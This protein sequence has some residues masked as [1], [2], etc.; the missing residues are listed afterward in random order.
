[1]P[2]PL[3]EPHHTMYQAFKYLLR[4]HLV[5][6]LSIGFALLSFCIVPTTTSPQGLQWWQSI[7]IKTINLLFCLMFIIEGFRECNLFQALATTLLKG[8][9]TLRTLAFLLTFLTFGLAMFITND[10]ALIA[11][12]PFTLYLL[13]HLHQ[14]ASALS[15]TVTLAIAANLGSMATPIGNPQNLFL[16]TAYTISP[17][18][19]LSL[20]LP[21]TLVGALV[22]LGLCSFIPKTP[23]NSALPHSSLPRLTSPK[24]LTLLTLL[25]FLALATVLRCFPHAW[26]FG[27]ILT[28]GLAFY[29]TTLRH[30]DYGLLFTFIA[31]FIFSHNIQCFEGLQQLLQCALAHAPKTTTILLS[32][33]LSN[34]PAAILLRPFTDNWQALLLGVNIGGFGTLIASLA[35]LI[36]FNFYIKTPQAQPERFLLHFT[37][38]NLL[39]LSVLCI[40]SYVLPLF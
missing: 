28:L 22:L 4:A 29:R 8:I 39:V 37:L 7:D 19:F 33:G 17:S 35:S 32:Q 38:I 2:H 21:L 6:S 5:P 20:M 27:L 23:L 26:L 24:R 25:F 30:L 16:Y 3:A 14:D 1:M 18:A 9:Q 34:V 12:V 40:A 36:A 31:F 11:M 15:L 13:H 10:V